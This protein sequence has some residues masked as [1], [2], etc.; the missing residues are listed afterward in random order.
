MSRGM[1]TGVTDRDTRVGRYNDHHNDSRHS[2]HS[3]LVS[4]SSA[5]SMEHEE[6]VI[7]SDAEEQEELQATTVEYWERAS[8]SMRANLASLKPIMTSANAEAKRSLHTTN[9]D[10][11]PPRKRI[12]V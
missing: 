6:F 5:H 4:R 9:V 2:S 1:V 7:S 12:K 8:A 11:S 10:R 3:F